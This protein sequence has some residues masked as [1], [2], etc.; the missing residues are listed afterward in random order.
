MRKL[1]RRL[2]RPLLDR[3]RA[4]RRRYRSTRYRARERLRPVHVDRDAIEVA[5]REAGVG[6]G[7]A[8][9]FQAQMSAFGTIEGGPASVLDALRRAVGDAGL[10]AMPAFPLAGPALEHL[11]GG[12]VFD[13]R[14]TPS[15]MG[16]ISERFRTSD[17]AVRSLHPTHSVSAAGPGAE[18][19]VSGH[20]SATTPF[21]AGTPFAR[22]VERG[23]HQ[24]FFGSGVGA[25][26]MYH[27]YEC[28][29]EPPFPIEVFW[30]QR[31]EA[32][33]VDGA[34]RELV[35]ETLV[36]DPRVT[37]LRIDN[38]P[39]IEQRVRARLLDGGMGAVRLGRGEILAQPLPELMQQFEQ[40][41]GEGMTIYA[42][43]L[44]AEAKAA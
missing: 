44:L 24:L 25:I 10:I 9:F 40:M 19:L 32:R 36:H 14:N 26:T 43:E 42:D 16:T 35:V 41:L 12:A 37:A 30:P 6:E 8:V 13:L 1:L 31:I 21:G 18:A 3:M 29:R 28:L 17:S 20:E 33:C 39:A 27:A 34:G 2:P 7:D 23:A 5:L 15:R 11:R 38:N 4:A 22:L